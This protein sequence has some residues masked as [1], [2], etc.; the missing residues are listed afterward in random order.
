MN[1]N[2]CKYKF[3]H[4]LGFCKTPAELDDCPYCLPTYDGE[5][6]DCFEVLG[7][8]KNQGWIVTKNGEPAYVVTGR[9]S[10]KV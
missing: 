2:E 3:D 5:T 6:Y 4:M 9:K 8:M 1:C 7:T 10:E